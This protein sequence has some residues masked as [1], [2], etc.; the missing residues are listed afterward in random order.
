MK[1]LSQRVENINGSLL[2]EWDLIVKN[3]GTGI[4]RL[5][6][7]QPDFNI[8]SVIAEAIEKTVRTEGNNFYTP[9][10]GTEEIRKAISLFQKEV[11]HMDYD[12]E[13]I[14]LTNGAKEGLFISLG[15][16]VDHG[17]EVIIVAPH[18]STYLEAVIFFGGN[19]VVVNTDKNFHLDI[20]EIKKAITSKTKAIIINTPNNPTGAVYT[21][22]ELKRLAEIA[23]ANDL[24]VIADEIYATITYDTE[25]FSIASIPEMKYRTLL[26][27]GF[28]KN[29]AITGDRIG[30]LSS[31]AAIINAVLK[32]KSNS[33]GNT[34]SL[35]QAALS[36]VIS[37]HLPELKNSFKYMNEEF[38]KRRELLCAGLSELGMEY[39]YPEG[40][41]YVFARIP[42]SFSLKSKEFSEY[43]L[44]KAK[45]ALSPGIFFGENYD[46]YVRVSFSSSKEDIKEALNRIKKIFDTR[47][48]P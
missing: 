17:D 14:I 8:P 16:L 44:N 7:G 11:F 38:Q 12:S 3:E 43:L 42:E 34:N 48:M 45:V 47:E 4:V 20:A 2:T 10:G 30:Y 40:A 35:F 5:N 6:A 22:D 21:E 36:E 19:S 25:Q 31:S 28:S 33:T 24:Y 39:H 18:W 9:V 23:I 41:F 26:I 32:I 29:S 15:A 46:E 27:N 1:V 37:G 13:E